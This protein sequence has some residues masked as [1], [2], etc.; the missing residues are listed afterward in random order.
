MIARQGHAGKTFPLQI[1]MSFPKMPLPLSQ[2]GRPCPFKSPAPN[3]QKLWSCRILCWARPFGVR[4][5]SRFL[6]LDSQKRSLRL[7]ALRFAER[8]LAPSSRFLRQRNPRLFSSPR[9][10]GPQRPD[11]KRAFADCVL[12]RAS[13][14]LFG[15]LEASE[16]DCFA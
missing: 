2:R 14:Y 4:V 6:P 12:G 13:L 10:N 8:P 5:A 11:A 7:E 3:A 15:S 9:R 16:Q 1:D